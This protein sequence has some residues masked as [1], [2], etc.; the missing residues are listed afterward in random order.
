MH[1]QNHH[2]TRAIVATVG[3]GGTLMQTV[4]P[5][6]PM[7]TSVHSKKGGAKMARVEKVAR[8]ARE[9]V[10]SQTK[11]ARGLPSPRRHGTLLV[12][13]ATTV[14]QP[15]MSILS[16]T[17]QKCHLLG[18]SSKSATTENNK[19]EEKTTLIR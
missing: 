8:A 11:I 5:T 6:Q 1:Q 14:D 9:A 19:T 13:D 3:S 15:S 7:H 16:V 17:R 12:V 18:W 2:N 4:G 10:K